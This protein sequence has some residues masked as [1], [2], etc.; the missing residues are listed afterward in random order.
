[1]GQNSAVVKKINMDTDI[2]NDNTQEDIFLQ[3]LVKGFIDMDQ[4]S[5][6]LSDFPHPIEIPSVKMNFEPES[7]SIRGKQLKN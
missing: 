7:F 1:M 6:T 3:W 5:I 4:G 2:L